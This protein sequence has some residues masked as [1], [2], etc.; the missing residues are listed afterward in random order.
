[1]ERDTVIIDLEDYN[2]LRD[3]EKGIGEGRFVYI[4]DFAN[5]VY[6]AEEVEVIEALKDKVIM[7]EGRLQKIREK[8]E[9]KKR[10]IWG[11]LTRAKTN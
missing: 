4:N 7:L 9:E 6:Y 2:R 3:F 1:M 8:E 5:R 11:F 10:G